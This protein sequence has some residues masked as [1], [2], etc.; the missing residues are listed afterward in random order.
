M[1]ITEKPNKLL[2][3]LKDKDFAIPLYQR[4]YSWELEQVS[5]LYYDI[6]NAADG[7]GLF[8]GSLL[9]YEKSG[10]KEFE[11][12]DGQ[13]RLTT[14][15]LMLF[16]IKKNIKDCGN[17]K[18][19]E[20]VDDMLYKRNDDLLAPEDLNEPRLE[21][22]TRDK[23]LLKSILKSEDHLLYFDSRFKS[24]K[25]LLS[26]FEN[27]IEVKICD[28]KKNHG[29]SGVLTF[30]NKIIRCEFVVM[31]AEKSSDKII[32]F[33]TL[34]AR[35]LELS[36]ADLIKNELCNNLKGT[37]DEEAVELWDEIREVLESCKA[38]IDTF[39]FH[40][41]N[42]LKEAQ[43]LR[44]SVDKSRLTDKSESYPPVPEKYIFDV[45]EELLRNIPKTK[46]FL[47][48]L[49]KAAE[50]YKEFIS[51]PASK[52]SLVAL[53]AMGI[54]KCFPLLIRAAKIL[55]LKNFNLIAKSVEVI[56]FRHSILKQDPKEL[57]SFYYHLMGKL[58]SDTD[59][60]SVTQEIKSHS[61]VTNEGK[62]KTEFISASLKPSVSKMIL[63]R[64]I[65]KHSES[66]DW[67]SK[68]VHIE[69][70]LPKTPA[71]EWVAL[72]KENDR[73]YNE[74][75][76]R[77]GNLTVLQDKKN[78]KASNLDFKIKQKHYAESR[79]KITKDL[80]ALSGWNYEEIEKRQEMLYRDATLIWSIKTDI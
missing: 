22:G 25:L 68:D 10:T 30:A 41:V 65:K 79:L 50:Q 52:E 73:M 36:I 67:S 20:M 34:N 61:S 37:T 72:H 76:N 16:S 54:N 57:E 75:L 15:L 45:Y 78:I 71:G 3:V 24:H 62:F 58:N 42:S 70:I 44:R 46:D 19:I 1:R 59:V 8:L 38:S 66:I 27:F 29:I 32:L 40:Y 63:D 77:L 51:P 2:D 33:K 11:V 35:G 21:A 49:Q 60:D 31:T 26:A 13:Q 43:D 80:A 4:E 23:K 48:S 39:L 17:A 14:L 28:L 74:Y 47:F 9:L 53:K 55:S 12:I 69:H 56:S 6:E 18:A 64:I 5:D 7:E